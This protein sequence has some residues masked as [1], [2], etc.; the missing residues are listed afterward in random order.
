VNN[1]F[2]YQT[3]AA[4]RFIFIPWDRDFSFARPDHP[5]F[6]RSETNL[7]IGRLLADPDRRASYVATLERLVADQVNEAWLIPRLEE[8]YAL[9]RSSALED[10]GKPYS[11]LGLDEANARFE[12]EVDATRAA[13]RGRAADVAGQLE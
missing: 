1:F 13:I 5:V 4:E 3:S 7:L 12:A 8:A 9:I 10:P 2:L 11:E 6:Y